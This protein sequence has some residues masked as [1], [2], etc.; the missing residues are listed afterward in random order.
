MTD[1]EKQLKQARLKLS[2][3][4]Q[5]FIKRSRKQQQANAK[6][7]TEESCCGYDELQAKSTAN[8]L[9]K[10]TTLDSMNKRRH[11]CVDSIIS[12]KFCFK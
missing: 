3:Q 6:V 11:Q 10:H 1:L 8:F 12:L 9:S 5:E 2:Q 4:R 7:D